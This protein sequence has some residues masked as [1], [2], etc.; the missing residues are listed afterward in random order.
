MEV[1]KPSMMQALG[2]LK[3][4]SD[5]VEQDDKAEEDVCQEAANP[6]H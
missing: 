3:E 4:R 5:P 1:G 2:V 6:V